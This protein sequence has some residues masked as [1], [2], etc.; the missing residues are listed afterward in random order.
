[1]AAKIIVYTT[2]PC[3]FCNRTKE[4]LSKRGLEFEEVSLAKNPDGRMAL[5]ERTGMMSF[6]QVTIGDEVVGGYKEVLLADE[7]GRWEE[8]AQ[9]A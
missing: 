6:P 9:A 4:L 8:M 1:M 7:E 3:S 5:V 2:E